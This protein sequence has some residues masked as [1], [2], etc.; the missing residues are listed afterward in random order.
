LKKG[1]LIARGPKEYALTAKG[2]TWFLSIGGSIELLQRRS[3][4]ARPCVDWSEQLPHLAGRL[5]AFLLDQFLQ[6]GW[7]VRIRDTRAVRI[8]ER[9]LRE[10]E[11]QY[12]FNVNNLPCHHERDRVACS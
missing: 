7:I 10:F 4:F 3:P 1:Y 12:G 5:A 9:G 8:T 11:R 6:E 2:R